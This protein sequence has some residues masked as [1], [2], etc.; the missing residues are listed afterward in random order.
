MDVGVWDNTTSS[1]NNTAIGVEACDCPQGYTGSSCQNPAEGYCR[2]K[3]PNYLDSE[4]DLD[5]IGW[6]ELCNCNSHSNSC[7]RETCRCT[8]YCNIIKL[9]RTMFV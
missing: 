8:V 7:D 5:L 9:H 2:K 3:K 1:V 4:S 6:G